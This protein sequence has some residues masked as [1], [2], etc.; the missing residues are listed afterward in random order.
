MEVSSSPAIIGSSLSPDTV[1]EV[2]LMT[3]MYCGR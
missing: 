3:C 1:G 2:P